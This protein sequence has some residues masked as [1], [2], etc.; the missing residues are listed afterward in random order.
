MV[1]NLPNQRLAF[2]KMGEKVAMKKPPAGIVSL[3][4]HNGKTVTWNYDLKKGCF[5]RKITFPNLYRSVN[6][7][8]FSSL[9]HIIC[10]NLYNPVTDVLFGGFSKL[11]SISTD[12][13]LAVKMQSPS[14]V[15][16]NL[17]SIS[18]FGK[19]EP[20]FLKLIP[21]DFSYYL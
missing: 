7:Q 18:C 19:I 17:R 10:V 11:Y 12:S 4:S 6:S 13:F 1:G 5:F 2:H 20:V 3:K 21:V 16:E 15:S 9:T 14:R 8:F